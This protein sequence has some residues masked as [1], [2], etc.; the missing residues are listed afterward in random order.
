MIGWIVLVIVALV[1]PAGA[2]THLSPDDTGWI[3]PDCR[4]PIGTCEFKV[5][6]ALSRDLVDCILGCARP[7]R[8]PDKL[9][10]CQADCQ[11]QYINHT[12][13]LA[14]CPT[15][16]DPSSA[17]AAF[18]DFSADLNRLIYANQ[19]PG[20]TIC[21]GRL[22]NALA[23]VVDC[24]ATAQLQSGIC[25]IQPEATWP[26]RLRCMGT[27]AASVDQ[28]GTCGGRIDPIVTLGYGDYALSFM[29]THSHLIFCA[30]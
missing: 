4:G 14:N 21:E 2:Q 22:S 12:A 7:T 16:L 19:S 17:A 29:R 26:K 11:A 30:Q 1:T 3:S 24:I 23:N 15:C 27:Y 20:T 5:I 13:L 10:A 8:D 18:T 28:I 6:H 25:E 9:S